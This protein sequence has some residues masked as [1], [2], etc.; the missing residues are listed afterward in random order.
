M[1]TDGL[2]DNLSERD[3]LDVL[4]RVPVSPDR[5]PA[6]SAAAA[7]DLV[8][9]AWDKSNARVGE[10]PYSRAASENFDLVFR[11]GKPDDV[12]CVVARVE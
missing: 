7:R 3:V 2:F 6:F 5:G 1:G 4:A 11:G 9:A 12:T 8:F 10:T